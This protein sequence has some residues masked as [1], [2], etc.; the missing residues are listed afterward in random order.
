MIAK[1][2]NILSW[3]RKFD[4]DIDNDVMPPPKTPLITNTDSGLTHAITMSGKVYCDASTSST[5]DKGSRKSLN[6]DVFNQRY[7]ISNNILVLLILLKHADV[8]RSKG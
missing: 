2:S 8:A 5:N 1:K 6:S 7:D 4:G 3:K